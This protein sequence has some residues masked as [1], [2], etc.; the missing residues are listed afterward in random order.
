MALHSGRGRTKPTRQQRW[1]TGLQGLIVVGSAQLER[2]TAKEATQGRTSSFRA[3]A[4]TVA[5]IAA[6]IDLHRHA[7]QAAMAFSVTPEEAAA[8]HGMVGV[9]FPPVAAR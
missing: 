4:G 5:D 6:P 1:H 7:A 8:P 2:A 3:H 9:I